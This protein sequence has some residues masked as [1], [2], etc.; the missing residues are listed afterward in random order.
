MKSKFLRVLF[1]VMGASVFLVACSTTEESGKIVEDSEEETV[2]TGSSGEVLVIDEDSLKEDGYF[3]VLVKDGDD[4]KIKD[5]VAY[6]TDYTND[7]WGNITFEVKDLKIVNVTDFKDS[8]DTEYKELL[9]LKYKL[10]NSDSSEK[11]IM[12]KNAVLV[13]DDDKEIEAEV[14]LDYWDHELLTKDKYKEGY[15]HFK[16]KEENKLTD[17]KRIKITFTAEDS[18]KDEEEHTYTIDL[19]LSPA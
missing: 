18:E 15:I 8:D 9:S 10:T 11:H 5:I 13:L 16:V 2:F 14:F 3:K 17:I 19:P 4:P 7:G 6:D 12:P 1:V